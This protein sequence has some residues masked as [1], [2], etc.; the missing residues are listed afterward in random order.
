[1]RKITDEKIEMWLVGFGANLR[2]LRKAKRF[3]QVVLARECGVSA[4]YISA[5]ERGK[6]D[7]SIIILTRLASGL[8][9]PLSKL[10]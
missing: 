9:L 1:M 2:R 5:I 7:P 10:F 8:V 3:S 6:A 4:G